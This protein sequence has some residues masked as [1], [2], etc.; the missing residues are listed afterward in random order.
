MLE[1]KGHSICIQSAYS[2]DTYADQTQNA[3]LKSAKEINRGS[4]VCQSASVK[5]HSA[6]LAQKES[7]TRQMDSSYNI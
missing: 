1:L 7:K 3:H 2:A 5:T 6:A 4:K